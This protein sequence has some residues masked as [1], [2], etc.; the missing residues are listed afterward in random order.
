MN[1]PPVPGL[2]MAA[3]MAASATALLCWW[4]VWR[5]SRINWKRTPEGRHVM[6]LT[7]ALALMFTLTVAFNV[8]PVP[9]LWKAVASV[10]LFGAIGAEMWTRNTLLHDAQR[11][12][13]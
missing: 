4:F 10:V 7:I 6:R 12:D 2:M 3:L 9:V 13:D 5:Y 8:A 1:E 11:E